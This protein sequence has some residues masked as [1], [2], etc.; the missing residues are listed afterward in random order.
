[1]AMSVP[2]QG[3]KAADDFMMIWT[4]F[5]KMNMNVLE[6]SAPRTTAAHLSKFMNNGLPDS[7]TFYFL[8]RLGGPPLG[9]RSLPPPKPNAWKLDAVKFL[10]CR[11]CTPPQSSV[12]VGEGGQGQGPGPVDLKQLE[13]QPRQ[14]LRSL[15]RLL[16]YLTPADPCATVA[17]CTEH[18]RPLH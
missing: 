2:R 17:P 4:L 1:M 12:C 18:P 11:C 14:P 6:W 8:S 3:A 15:L 16:T 9:R 7:D 10:L 5:V 13:L